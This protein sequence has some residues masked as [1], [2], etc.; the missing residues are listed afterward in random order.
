M[1]HTSARGALGPERKEGCS[2]HLHPITAL[3]LPSHRGEGSRVF[4]F[5]LTLSGPVRL[6][7]PR[8]SGQL[9]SH[10]ASKQLLHPTRG[11]GISSLG[12]VRH[13]HF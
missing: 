2:V 4:L 6:A 7:S 9:G 12:E 5:T 13:A 3:Y 8:R 1:G 10:T 11:G